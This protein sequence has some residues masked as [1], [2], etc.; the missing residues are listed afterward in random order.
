MRANNPASGAG[1]PSAVQIVPIGVGMAIIGLDYRVTFDLW[2]NVNGPLP[3]G[4]AGSTEAFMAGV[5]FTAPGRV[6]IEIGTDRGTYFTV[7]GEGGVATDVRSFTNDGFNAPGINVGPS[8][9]TSD[10]YYA[11]IFPGGVDVGALPVQGGTDNQTG[12]TEVG[13]MAFD[14]HEIQIDKIGSQVDFYI[15]GLLIASDPDAAT[16]GNVMLG[17]GDYFASVSDA[18]QWSFGLF[19][20]LRVV[21][22]SAIDGD[23]ND[24]GEYDCLDV[25]ALVADIAAGNHTADFDLTEDGLVDTVDLNAWLAEAGAAN[26]DSHNPYLAGDANLD[27]VVDVPDFNIWNSNKF[28]D[29]AAWCSGDF[30]ADGVV[31]VSDFNVWNGQ[32]FTSS[33]GVAG[34]P[35][36]A[37]GGALCVLATAVF[38]LR[39]RRR[40]ARV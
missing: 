14:W 19:D 36:P 10:P 38:L 33:D 16:S 8:N 35:E 30:T 12:T 17:Y 37:S 18:P 25:D 32:K 3:A 22:L 15:D 6:A 27:G 26:L 11:G 4:G 5:G 13:Q 1:S 23:F 34:V 24:D 28:S 31:D 20:N 2:M 7:T 29:V 9:D 21:E 40:T 39:P